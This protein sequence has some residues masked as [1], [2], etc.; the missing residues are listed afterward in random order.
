MLKQ[1]LE[2]KKIY[3]YLKNLQMALVKNVPTLAEIKI[4]QFLF[5]FVQ[6]TLSTGGDNIFYL[7]IIF[8]LLF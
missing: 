1:T 5:T 8:L 2:N 6:S 3:E 7:I 4:R